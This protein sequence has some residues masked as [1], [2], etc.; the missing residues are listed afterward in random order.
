MSRMIL[1]ITTVTT[2]R[3]VTQRG[4]ADSTFGTRYS[5][6]TWSFCSS[7]FNTKTNTIELLVARE[8]RPLPPVILTSAIV[9]WGQTRIFDDGLQ[10]L[11]A[12]CFMIRQCA[13][14][15]DVCFG[16]SLVNIQTTRRNKAVCITAPIWCF[17]K[18]FQD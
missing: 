3:A 7:C 4:H 18:Q 8:P 12:S 11:I 16:V 14:S 13:Y 10:T 1:R 15:I 2:Y 6:H 9:G 17:R 5:S